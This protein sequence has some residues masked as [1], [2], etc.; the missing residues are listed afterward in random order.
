MYRSCKYWGLTKR[1]EQYKQTSG[2][3]KNPE[4]Y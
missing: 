3:I 4:K 2:K 1:K